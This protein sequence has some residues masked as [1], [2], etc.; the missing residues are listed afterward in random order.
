MK[1]KKQ[2]SPR[3][4]ITGLVVLSAVLF[5]S[6]KLLA[7]EYYN[8]GNDNSLISDPTEYSNTDGATTP[9]TE[10]L[11]G[12][13]DLFFYNS[14]VTGATER[15]LQSGEVAKEYQSMTFRGN[16]GST[17]INR[18]TDDD[19]S[20]SA[21]IYIGAGGI[22]L[23]AGAGPVT[24]GDLGQRVV[25]GAKADFT[26]ANNSGNDLTF[27]REI[28]G[29]T[30]STVHTITVAGSGN[31]V[32]RAIWD[33][34]RERGLAMT[35]NTSGNGVVRFDGQNTYKGPTT[36]AAGKLFINGNATKADGEVE[37]YPAATLGGT[38][39]LGGNVTIAD[40]GGLEFD[41]SGPAEE[42]NSLDLAE[43]CKFSFSGASTLTITSSGGT[44]VG[45]YQLITAPGGIFGAAPAALK[46]PEGWRATLS[47]ADNALLLDLISVA[48]P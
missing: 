18:L 40:H 29:Y 42:H 43:S 31:T 4:I 21:I 22:T 12:W 34:K 26:I 16:A 37:V 9:A 46:L 33:N 47:I 24:F 19:S 36:V 10:P 45:K 8:L 13:D 48:T 1:L 15:I 27:N 3:I 17:Q 30:E 35:I 38:G 39:D 25:I 28:R 14:T 41:I 7:S 20:D 32:F 44:S 6:S 5:H 2:H 11:T 23:E